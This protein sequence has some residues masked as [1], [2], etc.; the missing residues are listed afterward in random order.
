MIDNLVLAVLGARDLWFALPLI[1]T[2][3]LVYA[4]TRHE[5]M[6]PIL[7]HAVRIGVWIIGFMAVVFAILQVIAWWV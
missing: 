2:V 6:G 1:V 5:E 4:A 3:S 7:L